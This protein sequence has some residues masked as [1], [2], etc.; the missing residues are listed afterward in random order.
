MSMKPELPPMDLQ[1]SDVADIK[2]LSREELAKVP[3]DKWKLFCGIEGCHHFTA[4]RDYG[5][6]PEVYRRFSDGVNW[7]NVYSQ[8]FICAQHFKEYKGD[9]SKIP[10][11]EHFCMD[12]VKKTIRDPRY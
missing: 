9:L 2:S 6:W 4:V 7:L 3:F 12:E 8:I 1:I 5:I 10:I 11:K